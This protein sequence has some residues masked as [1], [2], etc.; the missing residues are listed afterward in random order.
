[1]KKKLI[2]ITT[3][4]VSLEKLL[5]DQLSFMS[6]YFDVIAISSESKRLEKYGT[7]QCI[8]TFHVEM[9]R[10]ITPIKDLIAVYY[11]YK[12]LKKNNPLIV[13][14]HTPKAGIIG[15]L[16]SYLAKIDFRLHT[17]AGLPLMESKGFRRILLNYVEKLT[18]K[19]ATKVYPN[20]HGLKKIIID[21]EF[22][23]T[24]KLKV[25]GNGSSNG[26]NLDYFNPSSISSNTLIDLKIKLGLEPNDFVFVFIGRMVK[27]K[28]INELVRAFM[29]ISTLNSSFKLLLVG[30]FESDLD[31]LNDEVLNTIKNEKRILFLEFQNDVRPHLLI[32]NVL[33]FPSYREGFPNVV[34]QAGAMGL[35]SIVTNING[36]NEIISDN[37]NGL[38]IP[39][40]NVASLKSAMLK[41]YQDEKLYLTCSKNARKVMVEKYDQ[42]FYWGSLL[43][44]YKA[45]S[46]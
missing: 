24:S 34:M 20:S 5:S 44:E 15:M 29:Q 19:L 3:I 22:T 31:P 6:N 17:V 28:G 7:G 25:I 12:F 33:T 32:S 13:H 38:I 11:L 37:F 35:P 1:M 4:P 30:P 41:I 36:C 40:K 26:I 16:A 2:R 23:I 9:T 45:L 10:K 46:D 43:E 18:Y 39:T 21:N 14:T 42:K 8:N 27:D